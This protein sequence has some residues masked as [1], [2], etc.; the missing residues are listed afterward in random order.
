MKKEA[1]LQDVSAVTRLTL[2]AGWG[3]SGN[4]SG[5]PA[6]QSLRLLVPTGVAESNG[7]PEV[8]LGLARNENPNLNWEKT[9]TANAG[10]EWGFWNNRVLFTADYYY[11][12]I[13]DML[14]NYTVPVPPFI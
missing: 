9:Q 14:Y 11:S 10:M 5:I 7:L 2:K 4:L 8:I 6:Y 13:Y 1:W 12:Y 3:L